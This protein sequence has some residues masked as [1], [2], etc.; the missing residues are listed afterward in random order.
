MTID[1]AAALASFAETVINMQA[2]AERIERYLAR[3]FDERPCVIVCMMNGRAIGALHVIDAATSLYNLSGDCP[4][5]AEGY[6]RE[7]AT[8]IIRQLGR[9]DLAVMTKKEFFAE[10]LEA[11]KGAIAASNEILAKAAL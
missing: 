4:A 11:L 9:D 6:R 10:Q 3:A 5:T 7:A 1:R 8:R 2:K